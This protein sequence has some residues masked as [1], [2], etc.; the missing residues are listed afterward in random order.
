MSQAQQA[1]AA[2]PMKKGIVKQVSLRSETFFLVIRCC[3]LNMFFSANQRVS[4]KSFAVGFGSF[5]KW[6]FISHKLIFN[7]CGF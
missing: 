4:F 2:L 3:Q 5:S 7:R 6:K 1:P